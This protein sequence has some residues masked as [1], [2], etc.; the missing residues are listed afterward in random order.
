MTGVTRAV[1]HRDDV[2][3]TPLSPTEWRLTDRRFRSGSAECLLGFVARSG[4]DWVVT[5][6]DHP[7]E[8]VTLGSVDEVL[9]FVATR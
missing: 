1:L 3:L 6:I 8:R 2:E 9:S 5:R 4:S 7:M